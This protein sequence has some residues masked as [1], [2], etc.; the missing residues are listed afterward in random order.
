MTAAL[1][2]ERLTVDEVAKVF[3]VK[4]RTVRR[5]IQAGRIKAVL[6]TR[7]AGYLIPKD[8]VDRLLRESER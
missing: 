6:V 3:R 2:D 1:D 4:P 7:Q 5:W 8:E